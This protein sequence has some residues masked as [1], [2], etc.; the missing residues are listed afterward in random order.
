LDDD[1]ARFAADDVLVLGKLVADGDDE[2]AGI[3]SHAPVLPQRQPDAFEA[4]LACALAIEVGVGR[5]AVEHAFGDLGDPFVHLT[6]EALVLLDTLLGGH[7]E[8]LTRNGR[9]SKLE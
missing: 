6:E 4:R 9:N 3:C 2:V 5:V 8:T 1:V 7:G